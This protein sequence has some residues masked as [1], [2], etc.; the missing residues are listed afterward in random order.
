MNNRYLPLSASQMTKKLNTTRR[1][2]ACIT[3]RIQSYIH[4][5]GQM[6][7]RWGS[8][9]Y[10]G[11]WDWYSG[12][13]SSTITLLMADISRN[14]IMDKTT[15]N[16]QRYVS[17]GSQIPL[18]PFFWR[19]SLVEKLISTSHDGI[20]LLISSHRYK[21]RDLISVLLNWLL[22]LNVDLISDWSYCQLESF[23]SNRFRPI[24]IFEHVI[25]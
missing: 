19:L 3:T 24:S 10:C 5:S 20:I 12:A 25:H 18:C 1:P 15:H 17:R 22:V 14:T 21:N 13:E 9:K 2:T 16:S 4:T 7:G 6:I 23:P 11:I 8:T